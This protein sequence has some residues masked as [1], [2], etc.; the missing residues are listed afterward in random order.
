MN[1][2]I[3]L[4]QLVD[5]MK[6]IGDMLTPYNW[7]QND[8]ILENDISV[9]KTRSIDI[10]GYSVLIHFSRSDYGSHFVETLQVFGDKASF[11]PF[12]LV[13]KLGQKF[14]GGHNL[15]LVEIIRDNRKIYCWTVT[16]DKTGKPIKPPI[17]LQTTDCEYDGLR[18]NYMYPSQVNFH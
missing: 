8:P 11:L 7:P 6:M 12:C 16:L 4:E 13:A 9:L 2:K 5:E 14:L 15:Y 3:P 10:D 17:P 1:K 18:Y